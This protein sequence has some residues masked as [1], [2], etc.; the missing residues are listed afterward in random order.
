MTRK[1]ILRRKPISFDTTLRNPER[2]PQFISV[3]SEFENQLLTSEV[4]LSIEAEIIRQKI[5]EPTQQTMGTYVKKYSGKF[6]FIAKDLSDNAEQNVSE[7]YTEWSNNEK[8]VLSREQVIYLL[9]NTITAHKEAGWEGGWESRLHT[10][11]NFLNELGLVIV[12]KNKIIKISEVGK[13]MIKNYNQG[14]RIPNSDLCFEKS[15]FLMAFAKY[16]TNNPYRSNTIKVNFFSLVLNTIKELKHIYKRKGLA[17]N[18]LPFVIVWNNNDYKT[19]AKFIHQFRDEFGYNCSSTLVYE[20]AMNFLDEQKEK[21]ILCKARKSFIEEKQQDYKIE[22]ITKETPDEIV[23]K[24]RL[25]QLVSLKGNANFLDL[26]S[27][28]SD[29]I[30][31]ICNKFNINKEFD[32]AENYFEYLNKIENTLLFKSD[33]TYFGK[34]GEEKQKL[35]SLLAKELEWNAL[36]TEMKLTVSKK[37]SQY[38]HFKYIPEPARL[39]FL[40]AIALRKALPNVIII[41]NY[42][43]DDTGYPYN[44]AKGMSV[45]SSG[46]DIELIENTIYATCEPTL[47][48]ASQ[49][50]AVNEIPAIVDHLFKIYDN[51]KVNITDLFSIFLVPKITD[52]ANNAIAEVKHS[53]N[54]HIY[55]WQ[56]D[57]FIEFSKSVKSLSDYKSQRAYTKRRVMAY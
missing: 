15:A 12:A 48:S 8:G 44:T 36:K 35:I 31:Y 25:T 28:E 57:D 56:V 30:E 2:I 49:Y 7:L 4:A 51:K 9:Q 27:N 6:H 21:L 3:L 32:S 24:L 11:F 19:L 55:A 34:H 26:N 54:V 20:Y 1:G 39:E 42:I 18:D 16:Q 23:R 50:Q 43:S 13:L 41:P 29:K 47:S 14:Y 40:S 5:F 38:E 46:A 22:K 10:Q 17:I 52:R 53:Q 45:N 37:G 33:V